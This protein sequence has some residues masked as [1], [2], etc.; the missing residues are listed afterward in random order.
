M[1]NSTKCGCPLGTIHRCAEHQALEAHARVAACCAGSLL[2][3]VLEPLTAQQRFDTLYI[4]S[5]EIA[6]RMRVSRPAVLHA[7]RRGLLPDPVCVNDGQIYIWERAIV[8]PYMNAWE[9]SLKLRRGEPVVLQ[10]G[11]GNPFREQPLTRCA[12]AR[13]GDCSHAQ[14]PQARD[15]EPNASGRHCPLDLDRED[16]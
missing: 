8:E 1:N 4:S 13:D 2:N 11:P 9:V 12:A 3:P 10:T 14:C 5:L 6:E 16:E 7:R 15:G